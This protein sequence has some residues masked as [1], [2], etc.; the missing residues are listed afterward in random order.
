[1]GFKEECFSLLS[2]LFPE[3][4]V[5]FSVAE[6]EN[7]AN[8]YC[9]YSII[10]ENPSYGLS[11]EISPRAIT[12]QVGIY[13]NDIDLA[14][15]S[16]NLLQNALFNFYSSSISAVV[17]SYDEKEKEIGKILTVKSYYEIS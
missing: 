7:S 6:K 9:V 16:S 15:T 13:S 14:D 12:W 3:E 4:N 8:F 11:N 1:M 5:Y 2:G 17:E 10:S